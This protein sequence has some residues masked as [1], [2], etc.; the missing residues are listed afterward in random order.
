MARKLKKK[1]HAA[2]YQFVRAVEHLMLDLTPE[3]VG[4]IADD[5]SE[6][7]TDGDGGTREDAAVLECL[8][9]IVDALAERGSRRG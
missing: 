4:Y 2:R 3:E 7:G 1:E 8:R 5:V 9:V 6:H